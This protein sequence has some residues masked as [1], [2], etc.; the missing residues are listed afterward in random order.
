MRAAR[1]NT[2]V[3]NAVLLICLYL[4]RE[5]LIALP[6][7]NKNDGKTRSVGVKPCQA[8]CS[9]GLKGTAPLPGVLTI[10]MKQIVI[11]RNTSNERNR[12]R[13]VLIK[14]FDCS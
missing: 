3:R 14:E 4:S 8:A 2:F 7:A 11:P 13:W 1:L 9:N 5:K 6:T 12:S 10:I